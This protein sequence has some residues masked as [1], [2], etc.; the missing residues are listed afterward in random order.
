M[1]IASAP[2]RRALVA[3]LRAGPWRALFLASALAWVVTLAVGTPVPL[4]ALCGAGSLDISRGVG[5][6]TIGFALVDLRHL[7]LGWMVMIVAMMAPLLADPIVH[8]QQRSLRRRRRLAVLLLCLGYVAVWMLFGIPL[9]ALVVGLHAAL[10]AGVALP[11]AL[12]VMLVWLVSP[13]RA[14]A[15]Q[16]CHRRY[17][18]RLSGVG[19]D[20]DCFAH[21]LQT[22]GACAASC[23][24]VMA[25]AMLAPQHHVAMALAGILLWLE[26]LRV[27]RLPAFAMM[28]GIARRQG[29]GASRSLCGVPPVIAA[30]RLA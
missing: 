2:K 23:W 14:F 16:R 6:V 5:A 30:A 13:P 15:L 26:R 17:P 19:A 22:G 9:L 11:V 18:L 1:S 25:A 24:P 8:V 27:L 28:G 12:L 29:S 4:L 7:G 20:L 21:G 3:A 10:P